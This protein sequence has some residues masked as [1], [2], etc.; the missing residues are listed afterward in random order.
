MHCH[1]DVVVHRMPSGTSQ[2]RLGRICGAA[3]GRGVVA[4]PP[5]RSARCPRHLLL[6]DAAPSRMFLAAQHVVL[7]LQGIHAASQ[8]YW[9]KRPSLPASSVLQR[10]PRSLE[11]GRQVRRS[12]IASSSRC[13]VTPAAAT[14]ACRPSPPPPENNTFAAVT[15][16]LSPSHPTTDKFC[17]STPDQVRQQGRRCGAA[18]GVGARHWQRGRPHTRQ[19]EPQHGQVHTA[20]ADPL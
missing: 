14:A 16:T 17:P 13:C 1:F 11:L 2:F 4:V 12:V 9:E 7:L 10:L 5:L 20:A 6:F 18:S 3:A 19:H 15:L 8:A